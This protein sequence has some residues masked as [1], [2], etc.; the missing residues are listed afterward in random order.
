M[1]PHGRASLAWFAIVAL[2]GIGILAALGQWGKT[3]GH[4]RAAVQP[5]APG[6]AG[7]SPARVRLALFVLIALMFSKFVYLSSLTS[8]YIFYLMHRFHLPAQTAQVYLFVFLAASAAGVVIGGPLGDAIG[9]K[10]V[11]W[12]SILGILP[13]TLALP[14]A[15]LPVTVGLSVVIGLMLSS[16]FSI[17]VVYAQ[18]LMP[19]RVGLVSGLFFGLA[20]GLGGIG[21]AALGELADL[22]SLSLVYRICSFLPAIGVL[23]VFLP[24]LR[25]AKA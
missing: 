18:D 19:G 17:I 20:F 6:H 9:R 24:N 25:P 1:L 15:S 16:A 21:A 22:T 2:G 13:F 14:Y 7:L 10:L 8:Y 4:S 11:I 12:I 23:A 5:V 3:N